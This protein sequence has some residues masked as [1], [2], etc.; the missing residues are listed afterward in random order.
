M[1][2]NHNSGNGMKVP[3]DTLPIPIPYQVLALEQERNYLFQYPLERLAR[4]IKAAGFSCEHCGDC[5]RQ[6]I[7]R[8][9]FLLDRD[10]AVLEQIDPESLE[11]SPD[12]EFCDQH[13]TLYTSG[14]SIRMKGGNP[15]TCWF[16]D[17]NRCVIYDQRCSICRIYP[18]MLR[19]VRDAGGMFSWRRVARPGKHGQCHADIPDEECV[20]IAREVKEYENAFLTQQISFLE[21]VQDYFT[22]NSLVHDNTQYWR[23]LSQISLRRPVTIR[24]Y[25]AGEL[26]ECRY[27]SR[28][29]V[30]CTSHY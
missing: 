25:R 5:C 2:G 4:D 19:R 16:L 26:V 27:Q 9:I 29:E 23:G 18:H 28:K 10:V 7:N 6:H 12:P 24:V 17:R 14:Y 22:K 30:A 3:G 15:R 1:P 13:G 11:P 20:T 21:T 8:E